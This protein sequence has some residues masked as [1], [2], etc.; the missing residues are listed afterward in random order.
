MRA[1]Q[2]LVRGV[3]ELAMMEDLAGIQHVVRTAHVAIVI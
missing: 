3:P 2:R 1:L